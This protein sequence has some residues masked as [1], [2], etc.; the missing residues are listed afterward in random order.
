MNIT[1]SNITIKSKKQCFHIRFMYLGTRCFNI[2][3]NLFLERY[4]S[5]H[6]KEF[7]YS[8]KKLVYLAS[9]PP[10]AT[11]TNRCLHGSL[12][13]WAKPTPPFQAKAFLEIAVEQQTLLK[14][15]LIPSNY[16]IFGC[17]MV[18]CHTQKEAS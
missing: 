7:F 3:F 11:A 5:R 12:G 13:M 14:T 6:F 15:S 4:F 8:I 16:S 9:G 10:I 17:S 2:K 18:K 1:Q